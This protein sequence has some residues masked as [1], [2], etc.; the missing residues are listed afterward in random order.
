MNTKQKALVI[1]PV[2]NEEKRLAKVI[3]KIP[4]QVLS[5]KVDILVANDGST[6]NSKKIAINKKCLLVNHPKH[7]GYGYSV[8]DGFNY[9]LK[10]SYDYV[11]K[12]DG[13]GQHDSFYVGTILKILLR[14]EVNYVISSR[15]L[16]TIDRVDS[17]P[18]I[19]RLVN[20]MCT[21]AI[22][23]ITNL[24]LSDVFCGIFG[25]T[26]DLVSKLDLK[27]DSYGLE[28]EMILQSYFHKARF[29]EIPHPLI[30]T[31]ES[32]KFLKTYGKSDRGSLG[33]RL[34]VYAGIILD[35]LERL[36]IGDF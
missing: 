20:T 29:L 18:I 17:P 12:L 15:Y 14:G 10:H 13:D 19:R 16:R 8:K 34:G 31:K 23:S 33:I 24:G 5:V 3:N 30:Y 21:G 35:T 9:A 22:N 6:D 36:G 28:L 25:L 27:T 4:R 26:K 7:L 11:I 1:I 2:F 32:S